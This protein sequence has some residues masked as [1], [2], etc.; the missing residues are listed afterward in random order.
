MGQRI[1]DDVTPAQPLLLLGDRPHHRLD[2]I[3]ASSHQDH[4]G[5]WA[6]FSLRQKIRRD[7]GRVGVG[8]CDNQNL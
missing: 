8:V 4:L 3:S 6:V 7:L 5:I 1:L 2:E